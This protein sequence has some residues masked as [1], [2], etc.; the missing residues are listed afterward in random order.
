MK[1]FFPLLLLSSCFAAPVMAQGVQCGPRDVIIEQ[2]EN[3]YQE[4]RRSAGLDTGNS[5]VELFA[6]DQTGSWTITVT[7][8]DG[9]M[10]LVAAGSHYEQTPPKP[11]L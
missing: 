1:K 8:P 9:R 3:R 11:N 5:L 4:T 6:S 2:L 10:C 7:M